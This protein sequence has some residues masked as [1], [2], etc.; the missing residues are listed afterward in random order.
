MK[1]S[2]SF[3]HWILIHTRRLTAWVSPREAWIAWALQRPEKASK[4]VVI[5]LSLNICQ[6]ARLRRKMS[7]SVTLGLNEVKM[8]VLVA[9][10]CLIVCDSMDSSPPGS[11]VHGILQAR[12]LQWA[13]IPFSRGS[14]G[15]GDWTRGSNPGLLHCRQILYYLSHQG[16]KSVYY[17]I[18]VT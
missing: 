2:N 8:K 15:P 5:W 3:I 17:V 4:N 18:P 16:I 6:L 14:S 12:I 1:I 13:A 11:S 7:N 10:Q 9:Q